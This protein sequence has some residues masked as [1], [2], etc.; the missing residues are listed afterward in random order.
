M[1]SSESLGFGCTLDND[2][3]KTAQKQKHRKRDMTHLHDTQLIAG[4]RQ[5]ALR[6]LMPQHRTHQLPALTL[7]VGYHRGQCV[8]THLQLLGTKNKNEE[9]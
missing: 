1:G 4:G 7:F 3:D 9:L 5:D 2:P 8:E 6:C